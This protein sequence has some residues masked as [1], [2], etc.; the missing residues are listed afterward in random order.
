LIEKRKKS[1]RTQVGIIITK[2]LGKPLGL[3]SKFNSVQMAAKIA[4]EP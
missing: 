2:V 4:P 3:K 1:G